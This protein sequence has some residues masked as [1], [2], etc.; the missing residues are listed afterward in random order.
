MTDLGPI[1]LIVYEKLA[2]KIFTSLNPWKKNVK[3]VIPRQPHTITKISTVVFANIDAPIRQ[4]NR[5]N[6]F[7]EV[8]Y[9]NSHH[10]P[11]GIKLSKR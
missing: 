4:I 8:Q 7:K 11:S 1:Y 10:L 6:T 5:F 3:K 2:V 9:K